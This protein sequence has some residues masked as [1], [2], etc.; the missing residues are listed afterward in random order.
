M[1]S[2]PTAHKTRSDPARLK[3]VSYTAP[4]EGTEASEYQISTK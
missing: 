3:D 4:S 1:K 2:I